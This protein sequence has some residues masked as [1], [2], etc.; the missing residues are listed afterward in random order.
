[1]S[2]RIPNNTSP[3]TLHELRSVDARGIKARS[4]YSRPSLPFGRVVGTLAIL[5]D[6]IE[7]GGITYRRMTG[8]EL[9][10]HRKTH[11]NTSTARYQYIAECP[12]A[13]DPTKGNLYAGVTRGRQTLLMVKLTPALPDYYSQRGVGPRKGPD[14]P[15]PAGYRQLG[16]A[17]DGEIFRQF[18]NY[19]REWGIQWE[20]ASNPDEMGIREDKG[21]GWFS[22]CAD[23]FTL[24][25]AFPVS[26]LPSFVRTIQQP[27]EGA[28]PNAI[29]MGPISATTAK[30][31]H[32]MRRFGIERWEDNKVHG[33]T[34]EYSKLPQ[35]KR[36]PLQSEI[37]GILQSEPF[38]CTDAELSLTNGV[39]SFWFTLA[40]SMVRAN[41]DGDTDKANRY[42]LAIV[43]RDCKYIQSPD[44]LGEQSISDGEYPIVDSARQNYPEGIQAIVT[45]RAQLDTLREWAEWSGRE[46]YRIARA[47]ES[48]REWESG[49]R[50]I[51]TGKSPEL[52]YYG[53][54]DE[55]VIAPLDPKANW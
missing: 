36:M 53:F 21:T 26:S 52:D 30:R 47:Q 4:K 28:E 22:I 15:I 45:E 39:H 49:E 31:I 32:A 44:T 6:S 13:I 35:S 12:S 17:T 38:N 14:A 27:L 37:I 25:S 23:Y 40:V 42:A 18:R 10:A 29:G 9:R 33:A 24:N 16:E 51:F 1:M 3:T 19:C 8:E 7:L 43:E 11:E 41:M 2:K 46:A 34:V 48:L 50:R 5:P 55:T 54:P 20:A